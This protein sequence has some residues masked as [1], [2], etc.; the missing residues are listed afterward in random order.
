MEIGNLDEE[1]VA[2]EGA[3]E[4]LTINQISENE[5]EK[6]PSFSIAKDQHKN[7]IDITDLKKESFK[8]RTELD[9][10]VKKWGLNQRFSL[11][12]TR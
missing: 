10:K 7:V 12:F 5:E 4:Q 3:L 11:I 8:D 1:L 6:E 2:V 9:S